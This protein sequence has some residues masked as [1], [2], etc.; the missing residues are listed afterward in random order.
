MWTIQQFEEIFDRYQSSGLRIKEFCRNESIVE[1]RFYYWQ[2]RLQEHNYRTARESAFH[3]KPS[4]LHK[5]KFTQYD[6]QIYSM[7]LVLQLYLYNIQPVRNH[8]ALTGLVPLQCL[9]NVSP[10]PLQKLLEGQRPIPCL[11]I[12]N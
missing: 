8:S 9:S 12:A 11:C 7:F 2:K 5:S 3:L 6:E 10:K 1:S 4:Y